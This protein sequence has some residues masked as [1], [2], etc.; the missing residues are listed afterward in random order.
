[1]SVWVKNIYSF[2]L[3]QSSEKRWLIFFSPFTDFTNFITD[4]HPWNEKLDPT[5]IK[6]HESN[7]SQVRIRETIY[8]FQDTD[9]NFNPR[10][11]GRIRSLMGVLP[12][13]M[14]LVELTCTAWPT[15]PY[16]PS[17]WDSGTWISS[18]AGSRDISSLNCCC[19][20][21]PFTRLVLPPRYT[22][23]INLSGN[24]INKVLK[25]LN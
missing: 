1:M 17:G 21:P 9:S 20:S 12:L 8:F 19:C 16:S 24:K 14:K 25:L 18:Q 23:M 3:D 13:Q 22:F 2:I 6:W 10:I 4:Q 15:L 5:N 11:R 7:H